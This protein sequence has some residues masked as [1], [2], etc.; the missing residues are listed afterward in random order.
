[1]RFCTSCQANK[2][3]KGGEYRYLRKTARWLCQAC[4]ERRTPSIYKSR[5]PASPEG[6][7][8]LMAQIYGRAT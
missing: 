2:P 6:V 4:V 1:M 8:K 7:R 5:Q 3:E